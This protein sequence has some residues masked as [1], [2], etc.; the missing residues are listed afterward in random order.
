MLS[1]NGAWSAV[2]RARSLFDRAIV[3]RAIRD[4]FK[5]LDPRWQARNPVMFVVEVGALGY[6]A[7]LRA[8]RRL[9]HRQQ[10]ASISRSRRGC[11]SRC[12]SRTSPKRSP[13]VAA[14][15]KPSTCAARSRDTLRATV[16]RATGPRS[17]SRSTSLRKGDALRRRGGRDRSPPT[18]TCSK[19]PR[20]STSRRSPANRRRSSASPAATA[21]RSPAERACSRIGS[22]C[23]LRRIPGETL[24]RSHDCAW[25]K[26]RSARRRRTRSRFRSCSPDS[27][28]SFSSRSRR[29]R[30]FRFTRARI[31]A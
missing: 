28:S 26:A 14:R 8:R 22:S 11:G 20:R 9:A 5:K 3:T 16:A 19:A 31:K 24:P 21:A 18:A 29:W 6:D 12:S 15:R 17:A 4:S 23:A 27:R 13:K 7:L 30:R 25:S 10:P 1:P 2:R